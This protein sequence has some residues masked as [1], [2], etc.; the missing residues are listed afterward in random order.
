MKIVIHSNINQ[1]AIN[2]ATEEYILDQMDLSDNYLLFYINQPSIIIGKHQNTHEEI[3]H[4]YVKRHSIDVV[5]RISGGGTVYHDFGNLNFSFLSSSENK[6]FNDFKTFTEPVI[7]ALKK[8]DISAELSGRNDILV[9]GRKISGN[10]QYRRG[11][12]MFCHGTLLFNSDIDAIVSA[13]TVKVDKIQSKGI[14][15]IRSRVANISEFLTTNLN[16]EEFKQHL[17]QTIIGDLNQNNTWILRDEDYANIET[18]AQEKYR[19]WDWNYGK[20][21]EFNYQNQQRFLF[22]EI[23]IRLHVK[24]GLITDAKIFGDFFSEHNI[25][26][27]EQ[28]LLNLA[29]DTPT[30]EAAFIKLDCPKYFP[31]L[32]R[33][34]WLKLL[35]V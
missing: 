7:C 20:S 17:I 8:L 32:N 4:D 3:N 22:G 14:K 33:E 16:I 15:S 11:N 5:R 26:E 19:S 23:D 28:G 30:L 31:D 21:P 13:L 2:L 25:S 24:E 34:D 18:L 35:G 9:N 10:A 6:V 1:P 12:R 29:Y 27:L